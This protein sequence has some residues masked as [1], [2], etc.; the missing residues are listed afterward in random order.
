MYC[1]IMAGGS[2]TRF[3][4]RSK[5]GNS[6]QFLSLFSHESLIRTTVNRYRGFITE[7]KIY[8]I[9]RKDQKAELEKHISEIPAENI[10]LEPQGR[11]TAPC[12]GLAAIIIRSRSNKN[13][14]MVALPADHL[15]TEEQ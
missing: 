11:N 6:K 4:P 9:L 12:I 8:I 2:G 7:D 14:M 1:V 13:E 15:I 5:E 10:I 3:W